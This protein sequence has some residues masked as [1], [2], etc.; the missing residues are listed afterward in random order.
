ME[1]DVEVALNLYSESLESKCCCYWGK[2][3]EFAN[4]WNSNM[5]KGTKYSFEKETLQMGTLKNGN[6][7]SEVLKKMP[8]ALTYKIKWCQERG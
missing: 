5:F 8:K 2:S 3:K 7:S 4:T 6:H 1:D